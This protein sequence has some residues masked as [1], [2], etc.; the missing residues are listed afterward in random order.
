[1]S[2]TTNHHRVS[3]YSHWT[4]LLRLMRSNQLKKS[5]SKVKQ[6]QTRVC[7]CWQD[8]G[9]V[10]SNSLKL[11]RD[12]NNNNNNN[13]RLFQQERRTAEHYNGNLNKYSGCSPDAFLRYKRLNLWRVM[14]WDQIDPSTLVVIMPNHE[15]YIQPQCIYFKCS[16]FKIVHPKVRK[17]SQKL[18]TFLI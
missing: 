16:Y 1:M 18:W 15:K 7:L 4:Y 3:Q 8:G 12:F 11:K 10:Q 13:N 14:T 17:Q 6:N 9:G 2:K 5:R